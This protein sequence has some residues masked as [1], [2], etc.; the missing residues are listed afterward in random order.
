MTPARLSSKR[1][2]TRLAEGGASAI[3]IRNTAGHADIATSMKYVHAA[4]TARLRDLLERNR[5]GI[6]EAM[7]KKP[8]SAEVVPIRGKTETA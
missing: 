5:S 2:L 3:D 6:R 4:E 8:T 1:F 7:K